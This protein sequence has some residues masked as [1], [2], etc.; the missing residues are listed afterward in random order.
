M[1]CFG[2]DALYEIVSL[3]EYIITPCFGGDFRP[4]IVQ[5]LRLL[6]VA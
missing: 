2:M 4:D 5:N 3:C 1:M 6:K